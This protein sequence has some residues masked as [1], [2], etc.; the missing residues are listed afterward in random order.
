MKKTFMKL[1]LLAMMVMLVVSMVACS[2]EPAKETPAP[3]APAETEGSTDAEPTNDEPIKFSVAYADNP[4]FPFN[5]NWMTVKKVQEILNAEITFEVTPYADYGEKMTLA[6]NTETA[7]DVISY[8]DASKDPIASFGLNGALVPVNTME[9]LMP[10]YV[11]QRDAWN[12]GSEIEKL[13]LAD[14]N[15]YYT[16]SLYSS[17]FYD[18]G[19]ILR[20]DLLAKYNMDAPKTTEDLYKFLKAYKDENPDSYPL[21][22]LVEPRVHYRMTMP[23]YGVSLGK[24]SSS[25]SYVLSYDYETETYFAGATSD[26]FKQ[27]L[28][29]TAKLYAEGL[30]DPEMVNPGDVWA[31]KLSTGKSVA[32]YAYYDQIGG[33]VGNSEIEGISFN[34]YPPVEGPGGAHHQPKNRTGVGNV[35]PTT[36]KNKRDDFEKLVQVVDQMYYSPETAKLFCL[37][38]EDETYT[39][40]G[41]K[42]VFADA[43]VNSENGVYKQLQID[44]GC[45]TDQF[46]NVW[47]LSVEVSKY[48]ENYANINNN[49]AK[50]DH[51]IQFIPPSPK[52]DSDQAEEAGFLK[53][54]LA[55]TWEVWT[56][57]FITGEKSVEADWDAYVA[58]MNAKG[59]EDLLKMYNDNLK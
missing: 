40:D 59:I 26:L 21:T 35:F 51:A 15:L 3:S 58:E 22:V 18:G 8:I 7:P 1:V 53:T 6:L 47:D 29:D 16:P 20:D 27:Y 24:N 55:D 44:Y 45:G 9:D 39:M 32:T 13:H 19:L 33:L 12:L 10:N 46:Q 43:L 30:L 56:N 48:D 38:I 5:E 11:A 50:M 4:T 17:P 34:L 54:S 41:D 36:T 14:G 2:T 25:G 57:N 28:I 52:F 23:S 37:G 49:V 42:I 31:T